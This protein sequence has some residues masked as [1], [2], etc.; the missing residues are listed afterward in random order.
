M[1]EDTRDLRREA[2]QD[3]VT[4]RNVSVGGGGIG[5]FILYHSGEDDSVPLGRELA[6][7]FDLQRF[8]WLVFWFLSCFALLLIMITI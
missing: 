5:K 2:L 6:N 8:C 3:L 7:S 1:R 4:S